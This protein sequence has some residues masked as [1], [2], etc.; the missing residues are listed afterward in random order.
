[1]PKAK[2]KEPPPH[3]P[4][5]LDEPVIEWIELREGTKYYTAT[6]VAV[7]LGVHRV[8]LLRLEQRRAIPLAKWVRK[9][10]PHRVYTP[11]DVVA[12][13]HRL[14][15]INDNKTREYVE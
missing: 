11:E 9:P 5:V 3:S 8:T 6:Q 14:V 1:M 4:P 15:A 7:M 12:L 13:R 10:V 2:L